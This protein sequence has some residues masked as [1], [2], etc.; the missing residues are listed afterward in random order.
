M[1][2][3]K[4]VYV[5][6]T[7][8]CNLSCPFCHPTT[9]PRAF[10]SSEDFTATLAQLNGWTDH[11]NLH[12]LGEPLLHPA[13]GELLEICRQRRFQV[14]LTTNTTLLT[15]RSDL[16][17]TSPALRQLNL[18]LHSQALVSGDHS[19]WLTP[20]LDFVDRAR[21]A[22]ALL[23]SLRLWNLGAGAD[24]ATIASNQIIQHRLADHFSLTTPLPERLTPGQGIRLAERVFLSQEEEF[25]WPGTSGSQAC[26]TGSCRALRDHIGVLVD[27]TVVPCCLDGDGAIPLGNLHRQPLSEILSSP[28]AVAMRDGFAHRR[29]VE[30]LCRYCTYRLRFDVNKNAR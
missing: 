14:N 13:L 8:V 23:V 9:R 1:K 6:I 4:K 28:R 18:S 20:I 22:T 26:A 16:L 3:F 15:A 25:S 24:P 17:L 21:A 19:V 10:L 11:L 7:N 27:G 12:L 2:K 29:L 30:P 5:E